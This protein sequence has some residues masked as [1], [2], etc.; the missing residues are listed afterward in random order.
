[1]TKKPSALIALAIAAL[2]PALAHADQAFPA[3][4]AG[5]A[6]L[7]AATFL[8]APKDAPASLAVSGKYTAADARRVEAAGSLPGHS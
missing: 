5:H 8:A 6:F 4:L 2:A 7:P 3:T 1:M